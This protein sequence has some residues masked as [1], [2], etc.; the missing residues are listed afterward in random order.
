MVGKPGDGRAQLFLDTIKAIQLLRAVRHLEQAKAPKREFLKEGALKGD[1]DVVWSAAFKIVAE[2]LD[3][4][5]YPLSGKA[6]END[7]EI[8][9]GRVRQ[10]GVNS[11]GFEVAIVQAASGGIRAGSVS[12]AGDASS[13]MAST[14]M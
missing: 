4:V 3:V 11:T 10:G 13:A 1:G 6:I 9:F 7:G 5:L 2:A 14:C 8:Q 12:A